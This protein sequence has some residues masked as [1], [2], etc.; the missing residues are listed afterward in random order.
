MTIIEKSIDI[1]VPVRTAYNQWT[2]FESF[3]RFL[4]GVESIQQ[5]QRALTHWIARVGAVTREFDAEIVEQHPDDRLSW[6]ML[7]EPRHKGT[8]TFESLDSGRT[9]VN[10]RLDL[11]PCGVVHKTGSALNLAQRR[12]DRGME[13]FKEFIEVQG[14]ET[15]SWRGEI[16]SGRVR[17]DPALGCPLVPTWPTG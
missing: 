4:E 8:V 2:Q 11:T 9:R 14:R 17:P 1:D 3:P 12:V 7:T 16:R 5:P 15:G 13:S 10:L 6:L